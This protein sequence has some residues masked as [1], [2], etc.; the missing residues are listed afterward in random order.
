MTTQPGTVEHY[1]QYVADLL[2]GPLDCTPDLNKPVWHYTSGDCLIKIL[3]SGTI[4]STQVSCLNDSTEIRYSA[5]ILGTALRKILPQHAGDQRVSQFLER[6]LSYMKD[7]DKVPNHIV[8]PIFVC[9]FSSVGDDLGQWRS[10]GGGENGYAIAIKPINLH[11][12]N[13]V[14]V[15]VNYDDQKHSS[16]AEDVARDT[17]KFYMEGLTAGIADWDEVFLQVWDLSLAKL[18]A[19]VKDPGFTQENEVR[20]IRLEYPADFQD[21][22]FL[23]RKSLM[24]RHIPMTFPAGGRN[25]VTGKPMLPIEHIMIGPSRHKAVSGKSVESMLRKL[26]YRDGLVLRSERPYQET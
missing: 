23:Q 1:Q 4:Y 14:A 12:P 8:L 6:Y 5:S 26:G 21:I 7:D 10:Y 13:S 22:E 2:L 3:N 9:C 18:A 15:K 25:K 19:V 17:V 24:S 11:A 16:L 20:V